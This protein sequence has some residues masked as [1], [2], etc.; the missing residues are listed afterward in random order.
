MKSV[1]FLL[2]RLNFVDREDLF[3]TPIAN[4]SD[5][6]KI[7]ERAATEEY[8]LPK[9]GR[10]LAYKWALREAIADRVD[11]SERTFLFVTFS[12]QVMSRKGPIVTAGG[13]EHG[14]STVTP[15]SATLVRILFDLGR[16]ICAVE[17]VPSVVQI[18][19]GWKSSLQT[20]LSSA[21]WAL[22]YTSKIVLDPVIPEEVVT[23][24][25]ESFTRVTR[26]RVTLRIPNPDL[27]PSY[28]RLYDEMERGGVRELSQDMR[29][30][31][32]LSLEAEALPRSALD[33]ALKGYRKGKIRVYGYTG[34][35]RDDFT[36]SDDVARIEVDELRGFIEGYAAGNRSTAV[37]RFASLLIERIDESVGL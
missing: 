22:G 28:R 12:H 33:M 23:S 9:E 2:Y 15:P 6:V 3:Q 19:S 32:G 36:V 25:L 34:D 20:I 5:L 10:R 13:I 14:T 11:G 37:K 30:E 27:G 16:H 24:R 29:N 1:G 35:G 26:L 8:D 31:Q 7:V 17:E 4:D 21:S 18:H